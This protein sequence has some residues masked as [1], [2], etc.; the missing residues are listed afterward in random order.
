MMQSNTTTIV[1]L[2]DILSGRKRML[3]KNN[4]RQVVGAE[5]YEELS[6]ANLLAH[7]DMHQRD[8]LQYLPDNP[9]PNNIDRGYLMNVGIIC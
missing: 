4:V 6:I 3:R 1:F 7:V 8:V 5:R 9:A 2:R